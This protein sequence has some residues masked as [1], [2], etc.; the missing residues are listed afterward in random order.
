MK[1]LSLDVKK[2]LNLILLKTVMNVMAKVVLVKKLVAPAV[3]EEG[4]EGYI[5]AVP[6]KPA[7]PA[8]Y[9][10]ETDNKDLTT[11]ITL[12]TMTQVVQL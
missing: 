10:K 7:V 12:W 11:A 5:P 9:A 6:A 1:K 2:T 4:T 8:T 3:G